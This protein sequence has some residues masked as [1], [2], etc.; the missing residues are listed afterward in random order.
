MT[1]SSSPSRA[2]GEDDIEKPIKIRSKE[3][4]EARGMEPGFGGIWPGD[5]NAKTY[6]VTIRSKIDKTEYTVD[7]PV[8]RYIYHYFEEMGIDLPIVNKVKMCRQGCCTI[9]AAKIIGL[10]GQAYM[11]S[12]LGLLKDMR[13]KG[14]ILSCCAYPQ[15]DLVL[16]L[17]KEDEMYIRQWSEGFEGGG[18]EWGGFLPEDD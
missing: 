6:K 15:S 9:C 11:D 16:E 14:V 17:Q 13:N 18:V 10:E 5:P 12:P 8:D 1:S 2:G 4:A 3:W 7:V